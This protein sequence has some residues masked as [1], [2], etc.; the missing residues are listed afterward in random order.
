MFHAL[1]RLTS[2]QRWLLSARFGEIRVLGD[3]SWGLVATTVLDVETDEGRLVVKAGG[4]TDHH[5]KREITAH[6]C[7]TAPWVREKRAAR[8]VYADR[9][10]RLVVTEYLPG[11]LVQNTSAVV[12][13]GTYR[14]AGA[15][16]ATFHA[17]HRVV[18]GN[19]ER[20][21]NAKALAWLAAPHRIGPEVTHRLRAVIESWPTP[22]ATLVPTHGDWQSRNWLTEERI[23]KVIDFGRADLRPAAEDFERLAARE[24]LLVPGAEE[25][26]LDGYGPDP[27]EP[28]AWFRQRV[29]AAVAVAVRAFHVG[30]EGYEAEGHRMIADALSA[31][32]R[33]HQQRCQ[34]STRPRFVARG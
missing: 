11:H 7:W 3:M 1:D 25:A 27:R 21:A 31:H 34:P 16:L 20:A 22:P 8:M 33:L 19:Y 6:E 32:G 5:I 29:R 12:E 13:P 24:F 26:F 28:E 15:L 30:D 10:G 23:V 9:A 14:Q 2:E 4:D 18:D 17:Q